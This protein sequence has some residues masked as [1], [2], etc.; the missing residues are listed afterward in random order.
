MIFGGLAPIFFL[1]AAGGAIAQETSCAA[2]CPLSRADAEAILAR[3][4]A[5]SATLAAA[6]PPKLLAKV[7]NTQQ[8]RRVKGE[9]H[10]QFAASKVLAWAV[11]APGSAAGD[12]LE[13]GASNGAGTTGI[14]ARALKAA[15]AAGT[16]SENRRL[17]SLEVRPEKFLVGEA[18]RKAQRWP[19]Q[20][21]LASSIN[22]SQFP[23]Q[24]DPQRPESATWLRR[25]RQSARE[26]QVG[27]LGPLCA[28]RRYGLLNVDGGAFT[29]WAEWDIIRQLCSRV[30]WVALDDT[31]FK[32]R[33]ML[34]YAR[35]HPAEW[36]VV[37][38]ETVSQEL[39]GGM[40]IKHYRTGSRSARG[41]HKATLD[42]LV[43]AP[44]RAGATPLYRNF[45][46]LRNRAATENRGG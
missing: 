37:Y 29:G 24:H 31:D 44:V 42:A 16:S 7:K 14:L 40:L 39:K 11:T 6:V 5:R 28:S 17:L 32:T 41:E 34:E 20:L 38:E 26:H 45:A 43:A 19:S 33:M 12:I 25:E 46:L 4:Q 3:Q 8:R 1:A 22:E 13:I 30:A 9:F 18:F 27:V 2:P 23:S 10:D 36:E 15:I 35:A 21:M